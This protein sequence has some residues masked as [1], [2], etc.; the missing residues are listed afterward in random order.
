MQLQAEVK[1]YHCG[2]VSGSWQWRAGT[3]PAWGVLAT[4]GGAD[5]VPLAL[6]RL[7][8]QHCGGPVFLDDVDEVR[9]PS[10]LVFDRPRPGRPRKAASVA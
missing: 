6:A 9:A 8:C 4:A 2:R 7:R 3:G 10:V 1:C 5:R